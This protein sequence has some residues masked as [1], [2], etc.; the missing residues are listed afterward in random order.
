[1]YIYPSDPVDLDERLDAEFQVEGAALED[2][3]QRGIPG[4]SQR[5]NASPSRG[6]D[7]LA[8]RGA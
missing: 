3:E 6:L 8:S 2:H 4:A 5:H 1:M 7:V